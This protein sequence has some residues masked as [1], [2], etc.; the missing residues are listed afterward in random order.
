MGMLQIGDK[1]IREES[2]TYIEHVS[3]YYDDWSKKD[4]EDFYNE[5][6]P[7]L[8]CKVARIH[9][10]GGGPPLEIS[11]DKGLEK[12]AEYLKANPGKNLA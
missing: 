1:H 11:G 6:L 2:I 7:K 3:K 9:F 8:E 12:I 5:R 10:A 4:P